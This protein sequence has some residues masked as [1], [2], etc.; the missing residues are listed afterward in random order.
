M[1]YEPTKQK[2]S[3][4]WV[5]MASSVC[6]FFLSFCFLNNFLMISLPFRLIN[7][8]SVCFLD[9]FLLAL[10]QQGY[11]HFEVSLSPPSSLSAS[12]P[13]PQTLANPTLLQEH[14]IAL[15]LRWP[16]SSLPGS[17]LSALSSVSTAHFHHYSPPPHNHLSVHP[18]CSLNM[19][20]FCPVF[21]LTKRPSVC[22]TSC[23]G[24]HRSP[25]TLSH[26]SNVRL[27]HTHQRQQSAWALQEAPKNAVWLCAGDASRPFCF[28]KVRIPVHG[29]VW[30]VWTCQ[31]RVCIS[32]LLHAYV[33]PAVQA[34][35]LCACVCLAEVEHRSQFVPFPRNCLKKMCCLLSVFI[36]ALVAAVADVNTAV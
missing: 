14:C 5:K 36:D 28:L 30:F 18:L 7:K 2:M 31:Q 12:S 11:R 13:L 34:A 33:P 4:W 19:D 17:S 27:K 16:L 23:S 26:L 29:C 20:R 1:G 3:P 32:A 22:D 35:S 6:F 8:L 24:N 21:S 9:S 25:A 10:A 15:S